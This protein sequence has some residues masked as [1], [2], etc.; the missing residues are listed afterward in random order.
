MGVAE[1]VETER[2]DNVVEN[3]ADGAFALYLPNQ[4]EPYASYHTEQDWLA[5]FEQMVHRIANSPKFDAETKASKIESLQVAN[6]FVTVGLSTV[7]KLK[8]KAIIAEAGANPLPKAVV[9]Q[10]A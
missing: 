9:S 7:N 4:D 1:R 10:D 6:D 3:E 2:V 5:G 8:V